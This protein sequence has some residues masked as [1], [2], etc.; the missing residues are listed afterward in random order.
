VLP[1]TAPR[2]GP[3]T[4]RREDQRTLVGLRHGL[5]AMAPDPRV[6]Q[7]GRAPKLRETEHPR[8]YL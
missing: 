8:R 6:Q 4:V 7:P 1:R 5:Q 2:R 3:A